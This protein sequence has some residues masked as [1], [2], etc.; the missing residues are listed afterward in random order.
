MDDGEWWSS[1]R[2]FIITLQTVFIPWIFTS[3]CLY[4]YNEMRKGVMPANTRQRCAWWDLDHTWGL[5]KSALGSN[6]SGLRYQDA[7]LKWLRCAVE[8]HGMRQVARTLLS[9][10][11]Q[12]GTNL[13]LSTKNARRLG[14][15]I[16]QWNLAILPYDR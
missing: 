12:E 1:A 7:S 13:A 8:Q 15:R 14:I 10:S 16:V 6:S 5:C 3:V 11:P 9:T 2:H 4:S